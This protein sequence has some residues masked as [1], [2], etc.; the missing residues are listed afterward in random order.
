MLLLKFYLIYRGFLFQALFNFG[1][2]Y[3]IL[4]YRLAANSAGGI[5]VQTRE[6][7]SRPCTAPGIR[8]DD[9]NTIVWCKENGGDFTKVSLGKCDTSRGETCSNGACTNATNSLCTKG[10]DHF[11]CTGDGTFP[12]PGDCQTYHMC[13]TY[14]TVAGITAI[15]KGSGG[16]AYGFNPR[17]GAC[18]TRLYNGKCPT[19]PPVP[20]CT[21]LGQTGRLPQDPRRYY[22]CFQRTSQDGDYCFYPVQYICETGK[23][24]NTISSKCT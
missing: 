17:T 8:C 11:E 6:F 12:D 4:D 18:D 7:I 10:C 24:F 21:R 16:Y 5:R 9:C 19:T 23:T 14:P 3:G 22:F 1:I 2:C 13:S 15:C 20:Y